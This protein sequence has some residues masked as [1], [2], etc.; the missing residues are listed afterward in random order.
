MQVSIHPCMRARAMHV[1]TPHK[2][3]DAVDEEITFTQLLL[4]TSQFKDCLHP[5]SCSTTLGVLHS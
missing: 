4:L 2:P 5:F 3:T 1:H